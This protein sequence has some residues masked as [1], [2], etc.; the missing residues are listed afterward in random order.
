[1][2]DSDP[3]LDLAFLIEKHKKEIW[4]YKQKEAN[5]LK[6]NNVL[7]GSKKIIDELSSKMLVLVRRVQ[8]LEYDNNTYKKEIERLTKSK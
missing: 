5:W 8:E 4:N 2:K 1:M 3:I 6:T 7:E